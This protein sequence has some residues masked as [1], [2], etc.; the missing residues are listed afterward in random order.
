MSELIVP[1]YE[2]A[3]ALE[4]SMAVL[5]TFASLGPGE[6]FSTGVSHLSSCTTIYII[7]R[8]GVYATHW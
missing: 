2:T 6:Q 3:Y 1:D 8:M 5:K 7:S 4:I